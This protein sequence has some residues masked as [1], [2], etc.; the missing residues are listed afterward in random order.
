MPKYRIYDEDGSDAGEASYA[1]WIQ[2][3]DEIWT[4]GHANVQVIDALPFDEEDSAFDGALRV[5]VQ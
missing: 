4:P 5:E 2:P 1:A 3:G